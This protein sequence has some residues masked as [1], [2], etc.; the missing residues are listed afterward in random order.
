MLAAAFMHAG[1]GA[2]LHQAK[3]LLADRIHT[4]MPSTV[5]V[6]AA[7]S[8]VYACVLDSAADVDHVIS[9][10]VSITVPP[11]SPGFVADMDERAAS[12]RRDMPVLQLLMN[13]AS[14]ADQCSSRLSSQA[15]A[16]DASADESYTP[17]AEVAQVRQ[18]NP[19]TFDL[20]PACAY[21]LKY[22]HLH[23]GVLEHPACIAA[24][25]GTYSLRG[26]TRSCIVTLQRSHH[27]VF[28]S[29]IGRQHPE[30]SVP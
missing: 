14:W 24:P 4:T 17:V 1:T 15:A 25:F 9:T 22:K 12:Q 23:W 16:G 6:C 8:L 29:H 3:L 11:D 7:A 5:H 27:R 19:L 26:G 2:M 20:Q 18:P 28:S 30:S 21:P 10:T 13:A